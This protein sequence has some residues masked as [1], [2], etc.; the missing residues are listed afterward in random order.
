[1]NGKIPDNAVKLSDTKN[2]NAFLAKLFT[3]FSVEL[4]LMQ[5]PLE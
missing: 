2:K 1:M 5:F 4:F 3:V